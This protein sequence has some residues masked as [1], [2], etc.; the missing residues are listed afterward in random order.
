MSLAGRMAGLSLVCAV[1][2]AL[3]G[4]V[5]RPIG[6]IRMPQAPGTVQAGRQARYERPAPKPAATTRAQQERPPQ[7]SGSRGQVLA[8]LLG[9]LAAVGISA[10]A[11]EH[12]SRRGQREE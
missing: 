9:G 11:A 6:S 4:C 3:G 2:L 5:R 10:F 8:W 1:G 12:A 7:A